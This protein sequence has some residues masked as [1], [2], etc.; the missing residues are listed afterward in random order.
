ML[1]KYL[2]SSSIKNKTV[3]LR[4]DVNVPLESGKVADSF[5][6]RSGFADCQIFAE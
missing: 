1:I 4:A 5:P 3:L 2:K 6:H